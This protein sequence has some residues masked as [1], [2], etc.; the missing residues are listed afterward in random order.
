MTILGFHSPLTQFRNSNQVNPEV[1]KGAPTFLGSTLRVIWGWGCQ[2][3]HPILLSQVALV[4]PGGAGAPWRNWGGV[5]EEAGC[6]EISPPHL[7]WRRTIKRKNILIEVSG[8][9][10]RTMFTG[11]RHWEKVS[12]LD[13]L[14]RLANS[15][16][17]P[18]IWWETTRW[19]WSCPCQLPHSKMN[20][21]HPPIDLAWQIGWGARWEGGSGW[22]RRT[23]T[24]GW[25][26]CLAKTITIL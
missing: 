22:G 18:Y 12:V 19:L 26:W 4:W 7:L 17:I 11:A 24:C 1:P 23:Y 14:C 10:H 9:R 16:V 2:F 15:L 21:K 8:T 5:P 25:C 20:P 13:L 3:S 6:A